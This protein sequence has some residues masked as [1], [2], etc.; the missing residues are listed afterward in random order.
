LPQRFRSHLTRQKKRLVLLGES[1]SGKSTFVRHL[2]VE[3][4]PRALTLLG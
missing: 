1:G 2:R 4:L 3:L